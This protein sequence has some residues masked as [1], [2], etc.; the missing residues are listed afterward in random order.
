M[1]VFPQ[2]IKK[3]FLNFYFQYY[4]EML[5]KFY[6]QIIDIFLT[7]IICRHFLIQQVLTMH[8]TSNSK[9]YDPLITVLKKINAIFRKT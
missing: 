4:Q 2:M 1:K 5:A 6:E 3:L 9:I 8:P 7:F